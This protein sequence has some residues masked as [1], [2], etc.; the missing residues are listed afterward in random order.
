MS[1]QA[2]SGSGGGFA[3]PLPELPMETIVRRCLD[4]H[5]LLHSGDRVLVA[6]SGG[7]D[8]VCL[9]HLLQLL[10]AE[11]GLELQAAHLDHGMR[12][13]SV[14][15]A[16]FV[17][18]LCSDLSIPL[19][20]DRVTVP[21]EARR[22]RRGLEETARELR[23]DFL[24]RIAAE[25]GCRVIALGHHRG[26]QAE[27]V[28]HRFLR[29]SGP[30][31]LAGM[32][33]QSGPFIRPLLAVSRRQIL[34]Y[35]ERHRLPWVEDA[36]NRNPAFTRNRLRH[37]VLPLLQEFNPR[38][39][40]GLAE[41]G[42]RC[43]LEEEFWQAESDRALARLLRPA[44]GGE[45]SLDRAALLALHPALRARVLRQAMAEVRGD[46]RG[47][48]AVHLKAVENLLASDRP[49]VETHLPG[50]WVACRYDRLW[51]RRQPP[52]ASLP[53]HLEIAGPGVFLL[54]DGG[55]LRITLEAIAGGEGS[56]AVEF[57][58]A[59]VSFPLRLRR[60]Q[61]GDR[62]RPAGSP[63]RRKLKSLFIDTR[64][65]LE[66]RQ[67]ALVLEG[68]EILWVVGRRR[69]E[70]AWPL[71]GKPVLRLAFTPGKD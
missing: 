55:E 16:E 14:N 20:I 58:P 71:P 21:S 33:P 34:A 42:R 30:A 5:R 28:L 46:L 56:C 11:Y 23:R 31:G 6:V 13:E 41:L 51:L 39:E 64:V 62:F 65:E 57:D 50:L 53:C 10:A 48:A 29:G 12:P 1:G 68:E 2:L 52:A 60:P 15:E 54:P 47:V 43:A 4:E 59:A 18:R 49:Q 35:L 19:T 27:T 40:A 70:G 38:L 37:Q 61:P 32:R 44:A 45:R 8:S 67:R 66:A 26:D 36:S 69:C 22:Q 25:H 63:G 17:A 3:F 7:A 9:L 24:R